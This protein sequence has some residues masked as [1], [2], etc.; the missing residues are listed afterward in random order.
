MFKEIQE[1]GLPLD[2][3]GRVGIFS[4]TITINAKDLAKRFNNAVISEKKEFQNSGALMKQDL[5][6]MCWNKRALR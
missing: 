5:K 2:R 6:E 3:H 4:L 1:R